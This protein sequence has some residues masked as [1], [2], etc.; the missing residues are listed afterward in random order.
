ML[1]QYEI[2]YS[3]FK[4]CSARDGLAVAATVKPN[5]LHKI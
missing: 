1:L 3:N 2:F 5:L 4:L